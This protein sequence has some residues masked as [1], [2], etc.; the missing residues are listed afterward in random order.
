MIIVNFKA[1]PEASGKKARRLGENCLEASEETGKK[2]TAVPAFPD[3]LRLEDLGVKVF[4]QHIDAVEPGSHTGHVTPESVKEAGVSGTLINHSERRLKAEEIKNAV[5]MA[6]ENDLTTVVCAKDPGECREYSEFDPDYIAFEPPELIGG[7]ISVSEAK[8]GLI[9]KA[10][11]E[12]DVPVL[13]GAGIHSRKDVEK[14]VELGCEGVLV[15][16]GVV[17]AENQY[18]EIVELCEGL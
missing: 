14:S 5:D 3:I 17:K 18:E 16:S 10:V 9:E 8:P 4:S 11:S 1:Y 15:A 6:R 2:V 13:T 12:S 7:D